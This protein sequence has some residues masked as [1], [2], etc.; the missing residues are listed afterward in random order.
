M[1]FVELRYDR[2]TMY[3]FQ[4]YLDAICHDLIFHLDTMKYFLIRLSRFNS[5]CDLDLTRISRYKSPILD[6]YIRADRARCALL[7]RDM[8]L[9][10]IPLTIKMK[11]DHDLRDDS[12]KT[13]YLYDDNDTSRLNATQSI[14]CLPRDWLI[15][16]RL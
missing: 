12:A 4:T 6:N 16:I 13:I 15:A 14:F 5:W 7:R 1:R 3:V 2:V 11:D 9:V 10:E 8:I